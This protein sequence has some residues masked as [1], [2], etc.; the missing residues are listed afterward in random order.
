MGLWKLPEGK[1]RAIKGGSG[2]GDDGQ[3]VQHEGLGLGPESQWPQLLVQQAPT[4]ELGWPQR[5]FLAVVRTILTFCLRGEGN[6]GS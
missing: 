2:G 1:G 3:R 6:L 4:L 5:H